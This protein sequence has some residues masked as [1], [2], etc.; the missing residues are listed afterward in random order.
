MVASPGLYSTSHRGRELCS[1]YG[2][3]IFG[4][5]SRERAAAVLLPEAKNSDVVRASV[6]V[7]VSPIDTDLGRPQPRDLVEL[8][9]LRSFSRANLSG[10]PA[11]V[12]YRQY[13]GLGWSS[14]LPQRAVWDLVRPTTPTKE[15]QGRGCRAASLLDVKCEMPA[16]TCLDSRIPSGASRSRT[17]SAVR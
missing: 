11:G 7:S 3:N 13:P 12:D 10:F 17:F 15:L 8:R 16:R 6:V 14:T 5:C 1:K 2:L 4:V 9:E